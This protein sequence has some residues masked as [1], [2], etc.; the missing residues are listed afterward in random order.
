MKIIVDTN[1][2]ISFLI[3][4]K[5]SILKTLFYNPELTVYVCDALILEIKSTAEKPK[6]RKYLSETDVYSVLEIIDAYCVHIIPDK[7]VISPIRDVKDIYLL[8]LAETV[9]ADFILTGDKDLLS[10]QTHLQT[11]IVTYNQFASIIG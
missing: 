8:S 5:L 4:K 9:Q 2:W 1:L 7:S 3:G 10:L 6:I 11:K